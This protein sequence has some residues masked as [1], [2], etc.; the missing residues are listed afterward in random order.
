MPHLRREEERL[1]C[2]LTALKSG[3]T[4]RDRASLKGSDLITP[5]EERRPSIA[6]NILI[7]AP[8]KQLLQAIARKLQVRE[9]A[10]IDAIVMVAQVQLE[11]KKPVGT[12]VRN[13]RCIMAPGRYTTA[14]SE[15]VSYAS[16][17]EN[18]VTTFCASST[19]QDIVWQYCGK[20]SG[21]GGGSRTQIHHAMSRRN[22]VVV[23]WSDT[24][25][26]RTVGKQ[27]VGEGRRQL[28]VKGV[29]QS[30]V[31]GKSYEK[32]DLSTKCLATRSWYYEMPYAQIH[33]EAG[34]RTIK[35]ALA[36]PPGVENAGVAKYADAFYT[37]FD[38]VIADLAN[39]D[40]GTAVW[41][42]RVEEVVN[43]I[44]KL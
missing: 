25:H 7:A 2:G 6:L 1:R 38:G 18:V 34:Y 13:S 37:L 30:G 44:N 9:R 31:P 16:D 26:Y 21:G 29:A 32:V 20:L 40:V 14:D 10:L 27:G 11:N 8:E 43:T 42:S 15:A 19:I 41:N 5:R 4:P 35:M 3:E 28:R 39:V 22:H 17:H 23:N 12:F 24:A 33:C 36:L